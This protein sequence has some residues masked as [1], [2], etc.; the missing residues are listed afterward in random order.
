LVKHAILNKTP[1]FLS[2]TKDKQIFYS[3][4]KDTATGEIKG[5][6]S[7]VM[8]MPLQQIIDDLEHEI[9]LAQARQKLIQET[10]EQ[11]AKEERNG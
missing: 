4:T 3:G 7:P 10:A 8:L 9:A 11:I 6:G 5:I 1:I 2:N